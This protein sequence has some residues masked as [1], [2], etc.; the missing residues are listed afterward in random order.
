MASKVSQAI[1]SLQ[2]TSPNQYL[3]T[4]ARAFETASAIAERFTESL[5]KREQEKQRQL[6]ELEK[7]SANVQLQAI[8]DAEDRAFRE[9]LE[10]QKF[11][12]QLTL[13]DKKYD[14]QKDL[15][16]M[17][18]D[19]NKDLEK[20]NA[21][22]QYGL[23]ALKAKNRIAEQNVKGEWDYKIQELKNKKPV[24]SSS[25]TSPANNL[26]MLP[27]DR[28]K[29]TPQTITQK[30]YSDVDKSLYKTNY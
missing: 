7:F 24:G 16:K 22:K 1:S 3:A 4:S 27:S 29:A 9:S 8:R 11:I 5:N 20:Y 23:E 17:R 21:S 19:A 25:K 28:E 6:L 13:Y 14:Q 18:I 10:E 30:V 15:E 2:V 12:N 26:L